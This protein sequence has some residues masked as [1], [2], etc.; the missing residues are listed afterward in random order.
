M[1]SCD[2]S[3]VKPKIYLSGPI[4][5]ILSS[6][7]YSTFIYIFITEDGFS[8]LKFGYEFSHNTR[9]QCYNLDMIFFWYGNYEKRGNECTN[10]K[11]IST[12]KYM[13]GQEIKSL[14][15]FFESLAMKIICKLISGIEIWVEV[16]K[17]WINMQQQQYIQLYAAETNRIIER[18]NHA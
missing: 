1:K 4:H 5:C 3:K 6:Y 10:W 15:P 7:I 12:L 8:S 9:I 2:S 14:V 13:G 18:I 16:V 17:C 11:S